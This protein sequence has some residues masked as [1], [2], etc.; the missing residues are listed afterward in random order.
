MPTVGQLPPVKA[1]PCAAIVRYK[2]P[3]EVPAPTVAVLV[4]GLT[5]IAFINRMSMTTL[6]LWEKPS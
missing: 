4:L 1:K 5:A 3:S 2:L 6:V